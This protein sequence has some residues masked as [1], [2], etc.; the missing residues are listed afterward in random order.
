[1]SVLGL[2]LQSCI[3]D[4]IER[5]GGEQSTASEARSAKRSLR[6]LLEEWS[7]RG[8]NT[9]RVK[10]FSII[11]GVAA[12]HVL[13]SSLDD[14]LNVTVSVG[15]ASSNPTSESEI[16]R[17]DRDAYA[18]LSTKGQGGRPSLFY[19]ERSATPKLFLFPIGTVGN[20]ELVTVEYAERPV[21]GIENPNGFD[22]P[23]RMIPALVAGLAYDL[24]AKRPGIGED[25][26][27]RLKAR[28]D[29][30]LAVCLANDRQRTSVYI[31]MAA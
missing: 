3:V 21:A 12:E 5:V 14:I 22:A 6:L 18:S 23:G 27:A 17:V 2:D 13:P 11:S 7:A 20:G 8:L 30:L 1:M 28:Y 9:W 4:A 25:V 16:E 26:I 19:L 24:A 15:P 31:R 10:R 29:E